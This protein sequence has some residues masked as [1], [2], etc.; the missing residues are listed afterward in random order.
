MVGMTKWSVSPPWAPS[1]SL[2]DT[3]GEALRDG[4]GLGVEAESIG[5]V[6]V[7][8]AEAGCLPAAECVVRDR[9]GD[10]D[11]DADH[12]DLD[13]ASEVAG[14]VAVAGEDR[15]AVAVFVFG[16]QTQCFLVVGG[17]YDCQDGPEDL[18]EVDRHTGGD[19]VEQGGAGEEAVL[20]TR[21]DEITTVDDELGTFLD[22]LGDVAVD[23]VACGGRHERTEV[24]LLVGT[25][26][27][28]QIGDTFGE[29]GDEPVRGLLTDGHRDGQGHAAFACGPV[30]GA[31]ERISDLVHV[32]VGHDDRV[33]LGAA[34]ALGALAVLR[35]GLVD[36]LRDRRG[37]DEPD[38]LMRGSSSR[39]S[40][41]S[42]S[43]LTT[44][45]TP[46]GRPA[47]R[48]SSARRS[49][50]EGSR[51]EGLRTNALPLARA[52]P[53]FHSGIIAGKLNGVMPA[54]TPRGWRI[55]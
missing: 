46:A 38:G 18:F 49:G 1:R 33:V 4:L 55:E 39:T 42:L 13:A 16:G 12:A 10:R 5:A 2:L 26:T 48:N 22:A 27:D 7:E 44:L 25:G 24:G 8:V 51:S 40:T 37:P 52:G 23:A 20:V 15:N 41:D 47:S 3:G 35:G 21:E 28:A 9:D 14:G 32:G 19:L 29:L 34:E 53:A 31:D 43:P 17:A 6:L 54:T 50:T 45:N 36:V 30:R 11:V